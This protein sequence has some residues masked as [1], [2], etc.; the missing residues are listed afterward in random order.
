MA[1]LDFT[2]MFRKIKLSKTQKQNA[3]IIFVAAIITV[4][5]GVQLYSAFN[6]SLKTQTALQSTVYE[7][8][9]TTA[10]VVRDEQVVQSS[11]SAI[12][13]SSVDDC[14][15]SIKAARLLL[16]LILRKRLPL[17]HSMLILRMNSGII[18][19]WKASQ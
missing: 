6:V 1:G 19:I 3:A 15:K 18:P 5:M 14:E 2:K 8:V 7:T 9:D 11:G 10:L 13:V 4:Y 17:I 12:T 16:P